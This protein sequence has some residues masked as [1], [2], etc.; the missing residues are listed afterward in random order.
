MTEC[1]NPAYCN[2]YRPREYETDDGPWDPI[3]GGA[4]AL[5]GTIGSLMMG[6]ADFPIEIFKSVR[7]K[8]DEKAASKSDDHSPQTPT[9]A[10]RST[11]SLESRGVESESTS[12]SASTLGESS[13]TSY[14]S[15]NLSTAPT[16]TA[17]SSSTSIEKVQ[18][19]G[20]N[21]MR[22][23]LRGAINR[24]RSASRERCSGSRSGSRNRSHQRSSS[25]NKSGGGF[26][27]SNLTLE[28]AIGAGKGVQRIVA[29]G[30]KSPMDFTLGI[31]RGFHNAPKLYGDD[32]VRPQE[33]VTDLQSGLKAAG[34]EFGLGFYDGITGLV[35]QPIRGAEK[36]GA[37]GFLKGVGKGIGGLILKPGAGKLSTPARRCAMTN[38]SQLSGVSLVILSW[39]STRKSR[40]SLGQVLRTL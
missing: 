2:R 40:S 23:A 5:V 19:V 27:P 33:K 3:S 39:V 34:K 37:A 18:R 1:L 30:M 28:N 24:S 11:L 6:V 21:S 7:A 25:Q 12:A 31:A 13:K 8:K 15:T 29:A 10:S 22:E 38:L 35:T 36:E 32:T 14:E 26:D 16:L 20:S 4:S 17:A 9:G